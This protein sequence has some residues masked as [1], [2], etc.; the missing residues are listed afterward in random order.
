MPARKKQPEI[1][2]V[3]FRPGFGNSS[4]RHVN[5]RHG[6]VLRPDGCLEAYDNGHLAAI[7]PPH[8][9]KQAR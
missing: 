8:A 7:W 5:S 4:V 9:W 6:F 3:R 1:D 2:F